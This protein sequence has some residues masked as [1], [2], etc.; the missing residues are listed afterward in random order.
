MTLH[1]QEDDECRFRGEVGYRER[2]GADSDVRNL[3]RGD[4]GIDAV[5]TRGFPR[6]TTRK[7]DTPA[8]VGTPR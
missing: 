8:D 6:R 2:I 4:F 3:E 1:Q 5:V 7:N